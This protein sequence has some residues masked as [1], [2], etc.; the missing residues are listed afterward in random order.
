[1]AVYA[2][3]VSKLDAALARVLGVLQEQGASDNTLVMVLSDNGGCPELLRE[4]VVPEEVWPSSVPRSTFEGRPVQVGNQL[5]LKPG[6]PDTF[7]SY[8]LC[9]ANLSNTPFRR[10]KRWVHEGGIATPLIVHWPERIA[11][12][13]LVHAPVHIVDIMPSVLEATGAGYPSAW[14]GT[15]T[16][17]LAGESF[18]AAFGDPARMGRRRLHFEHEGHRAVRDGDWKLVGIRFGEWE[19]YNLEQDRTETVDLS[20]REAKRV[21]DMERSWH[22]WASAVGAD[23]TIFADSGL[24]ESRYVSIDPALRSRYRHGAI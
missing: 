20:G 22:A 21:A 6:G 2:A 14:A 5:G 3:Q 16:P 10:F 1:M 9:W 17:R 7:M 8:D 13:G 11:A 12:P 24:I 15:P 18:G 19:L 4:D 23:P